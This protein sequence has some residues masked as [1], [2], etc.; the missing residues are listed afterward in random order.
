MI[1]PFGSIKL[2]IFG[3]IFLVISSTIALGYNYVTGVIAENK[4]LALEVSTLAESNAGLQT[5]LDTSKEDAAK[6]AELNGDLQVKL[7]QSESRLN[8]LRQTF[9]DHDLS[10]LAMQK[11]GLIERRVNSGTQKVFDDIESYTAR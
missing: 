2:W 1:N 3:I 10:N 7:S 6:Q 9:L 5:A 11:P 8:E 4:T